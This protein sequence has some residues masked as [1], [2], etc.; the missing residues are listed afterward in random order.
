METTRS[1]ILVNISLTRWDRPEMKIKS[2][3]LSIKC[4]ECRSDES[5]YKC[6]YVRLILNVIKMMKKK[7]IYILILLGSVFI[8]KLFQTLLK[9]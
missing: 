8:S 3:I 1:K 4:N 7:V 5:I 9:F 6:Y 2:S